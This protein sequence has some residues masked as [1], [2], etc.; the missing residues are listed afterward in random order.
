MS[1][2]I[3][4]Q[5]QLPGMPEP[6][7]LLAVISRAASDP[8]VD[9]E[10]ME[11]LMAMHE[12]MTAKQAEVAYNA[13]LAVMQPELPVITERGEIKNR[14]GGVQSKYAKWEDINDAIRP[15]LAKH[16]FALTFRP[17]NE[18]TSI[19]VTGFLRHKDGH[20]DEATF[21]LPPD[22]SGSKN[23]VQAAASSISYCKR[24]VANSL[25]NITSRGEDDDGQGA[26]GEPTLSEKQ[27]ADLK[28]LITEVGADQVK[29]LKHIKC[30]SLANIYA[31]NY[32]VVVKMVAAKRKR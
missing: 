5:D 6:T 8:N 7:S 11:R 3:S 22:T 12:R 19:K 25:L 29:F 15:V 26:G 24:Y 17:G 4:R 23:A 31:R 14:D 28:A 32:D 20:S 10:K 2:V 21:V 30:D 27:I 13:A 18:G 16:G 9:I 1:A